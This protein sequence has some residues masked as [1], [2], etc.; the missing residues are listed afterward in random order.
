MLL[1][2]LRRKKKTPLIPDS[3][4]DKLWHRV[5]LRFVLNSGIKKGRNVDEIAER[6]EAVSKMDKSAAYRVARTACTNAENQGKLEAMYVLR[7]KFGVDCK[8]MWTAVIDDRTRESHRHTHGEIREL[9]DAFS[10]GL[11]FPADP[12]GDPSE[13]WNCRCTLTEIIDESAA[14]KVDEE[15]QNAKPKRKNYPRKK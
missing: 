6:I 3:K 5:K 14:P 8:K 11:Q 9:D 1:D 7:D 15:W 13:V 4:K 12:D 2:K 10:N